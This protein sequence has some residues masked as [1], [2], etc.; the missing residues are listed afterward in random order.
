MGEV[1][2]SGSWRGNQERG[3]ADW[4]SWMVRGGKLGVGGGREGGCGGTTNLSGGGSG[5]CGGEPPG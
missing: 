2:E 4:D 1:G 3:K 5:G